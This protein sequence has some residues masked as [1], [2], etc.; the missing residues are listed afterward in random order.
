MIHARELAARFEAYGDWRRRLSAGVSAMHG[1]H[2]LAQKTTHTG[3]P[4]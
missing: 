4:S 1:G 3:R 2:Q